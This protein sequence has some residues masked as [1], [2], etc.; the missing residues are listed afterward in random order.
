MAKLSWLTMDMVLLPTNV[1]YKVTIPSVFISY[2]SGQKLE[3]LLK[4]NGDDAEVM[5]KIT[6]DN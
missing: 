3:K 5:L 1:G 2:A 4:D 6:F